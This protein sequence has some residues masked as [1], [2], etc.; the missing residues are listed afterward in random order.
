MSIEYLVK[1]I[2]YG[3]LFILCTAFIIWKFKI[4][5]LYNAYIIKTILK[6]HNVIIICDIS[7]KIE[8]IYKFINIGIFDIDNDD[9]IINHLINNKIENII[10]DTDGGSVVASDRLI[11]HITASKLKLNTYVIRK[12]YSAGT[13]L[14]LSGSKI[15]MD[16][17][18]CLSPT[19]PQ[20]IIE[21]NTISA[22]DLINLYKIKE[23]NSIEDS[24]IV[25]YYNLKKMFKENITLIKKLLKGK[26]KDIDEDKKTKII[27]K[28]TD[29]TISHHMPFN[30]RYLKKYLDIE[31]EIPD[32]IYTLYNLF[33]K[34]N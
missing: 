22:K 16:N 24:Y 6:E 20:M 10:I 12:A 27:N 7:T 14:A 26:F 8:Y 5:L 19:D 31:T 23:T 33:S 13:V 21:N 25:N 29:G 17:N 32:Y 18:A 11:T 2:N 28:L 1:N 34:I 15:Y 30:C 4:L 9:A 3:Y